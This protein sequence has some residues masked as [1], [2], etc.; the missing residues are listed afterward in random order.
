[1]GLRLRHKHGVHPQPG[2]V[3]TAQ[4]AG[5]AD[6]RLAVAAVVAVVASHARLAASARMDVVP[7]PQAA[8]WMSCH[9]HRLHHGCRS[10]TYHETG[11]FD[12]KS[13]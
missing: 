2:L 13:N 11:R 10:K 4:A 6:V 7:Q 12:I 8:P 3:S 9:N 5:L 1:M